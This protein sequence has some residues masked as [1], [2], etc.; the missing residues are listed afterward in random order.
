[1]MRNLA[2]SGHWRSA[3]QRIASPGS[4]LSVESHGAS[5]NVELS[6][7]TLAEA[8]EAFLPIGAKLSETSS[9]SPDV[10]LIASSTT[11]RY[12]VRFGERTIGW[13]DEIDMALWW[14][15]NAVGYLIAAR[16]SLTFV[17]AGV[18]EV[19]GSAIILPGRSRW[20][21]SSLV[22]ALVDRGCGY[23]SDEYAVLSPDGMVFPFASPIR[24]RSDMGAKHWLPESVGSPGGVPGRAVIVTRFREGASWNPSPLSAGL[25]A[26]RVLRHSMAARNHPDQALRA[27]TALSRATLGFEGPR[28]EAGATADAVL[29]LLVHNSAGDHLKGG[30]GT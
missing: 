2:R 4:V 27:V 23:F 7:P 9:G 19:D 29:S 1:M 14:V 15:A 24:L 12:W 22:A 8:L 18:V 28:G 30:A 16:T 17:H 5:V 13:S 10:T 20:G 26:M 3:A 11:P 21:K 25:V 6:D